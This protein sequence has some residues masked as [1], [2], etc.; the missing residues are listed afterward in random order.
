[1]RARGSLPRALVEDHTASYEVGGSSPCERPHGSSLRVLHVPLGS[2]QNHFLR[3]G[4]AL[5]VG[6]KCLTKPEEGSRGSAR[7][8]SEAH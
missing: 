2:V 7:W 8:S 5:L 4:E 6:Y 1:M 3:S